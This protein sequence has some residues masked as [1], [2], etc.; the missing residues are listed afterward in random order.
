MP[1]QVCDNLFIV[2]YIGRQSLGPASSLEEPGRWTWRSDPFVFHKLSG[3]DQGRAEAAIR[4]ARCPMAFLH[5][6][7]SAIVRADNLAHTRAIAPA[8]TIF[9]VIP[10]AAHHVFL[11]QPLAVV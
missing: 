1:Y 5:G 4:S 11:D 2:D 7:R 3:A 8:G 9:A 6:E 10:D